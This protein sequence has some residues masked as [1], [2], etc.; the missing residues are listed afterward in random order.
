LSQQLR[1]AHKLAFDLEEELAKGMEDG[2]QLPRILVE[3]LMLT[4]TEAQELVLTLV[5]TAT[6]GLI[7]EEE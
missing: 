7:L 5:R 3:D 2:I 4:R 1:L 6:L